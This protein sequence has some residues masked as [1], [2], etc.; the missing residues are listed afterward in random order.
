MGDHDTERATAHYMSVSVAT[1]RKRRRLGLPPVFIR[2]GRRV[3][4]SRPDVDSF[5]A[6][7]RVTPVSTAGSSEIDQ[8]PER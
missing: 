6:A 3:I 8:E 1:L 2:V 5:L 4:Y 7:Q